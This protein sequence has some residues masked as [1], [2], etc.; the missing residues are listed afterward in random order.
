MSIWVH[1]QLKSE[2]YLEWII[3]DE[4][5]TFDRIVAYAKL[6]LSQLLGS[7]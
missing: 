7:Q 1:P 4:E 2:Q 6:P 3:M 5:V